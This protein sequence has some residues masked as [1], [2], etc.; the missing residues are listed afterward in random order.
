MIYFVILFTKCD[1]L[2]L[3]KQLHRLASFLY[4]FICVKYPL[5]PVKPRREMPDTAFNFILPFWSILIF[6]QIPFSYFQPPS[7]SGSFHFWFFHYYF[8]LFPPFAFI[9]FAGVYLPIGCYRII[10]TGISWST[11][12]RRSDVLA[13]LWW[14]Q[15]YI[16]FKGDLRS[17]TFSHWQQYQNIGIER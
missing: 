11:S 2:V 1:P 7:P 9:N 12:T 10:C 4:Y 8:L 6:L 14:F 5:K 15:I 3:A 13:L 16:S 17:S